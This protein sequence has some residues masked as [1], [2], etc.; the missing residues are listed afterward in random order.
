MI[1]GE[2]GRAY[3][4]IASGTARSFLRSRPYGPMHYGW[5]FLAFSSEAFSTPAGYII[6]WA[7]LPLAEATSILIPAPA[8]NEGFVPIV[9]DG[10]SA[11]Y[12]LNA[13][14]GMVPY[15]LYAG[16]KI[17]PGARVEFWSVGAAPVVVL[18]ADWTIL[19]G[20]TR[21][22]LSFDDSDTISTLGLTYVDYTFPFF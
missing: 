6:A 16:E 10:V 5:R 4:R 7:A 1:E 9:Y 15:N 14:A 19:S 12:R 2:P 20:K 18:T 11:R 22:R 3:M 21:E 8:T 13:T 17:S